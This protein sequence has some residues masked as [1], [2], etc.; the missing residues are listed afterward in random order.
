LEAS[1]TYESNL[2]DASALELSRPEPVS[3]ARSAESVAKEAVRLGSGLALSAV[4]GLA[5][6]VRAGGVSLLEHALG[7]PLGMLVVVV[8]AAPALL[9]RLALI[10]APLRP[11][12]VSAAIA[13]AVFGA[14]L[15]LAG[16]SPAMAMLVVS[17]E[18]P[19]AAAWMTGLG[20]T[21]GGSIGLVRLFAE[22]HQGLSA[23]SLVAKG[24]VLMT[25]VLFT[26][27]ACALAARAWGA[28]LPLLGGAR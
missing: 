16:L 7:A 9:V 21:L 1:V 2:L 3:A 12:R 20:L 19:G 11:A 14:G 26:A 25:L 6:G 13:E 23:V 5:L 4:F 22:I 28:W 27:L 18:S 24:R 17:I 10:D 8:V 15:V